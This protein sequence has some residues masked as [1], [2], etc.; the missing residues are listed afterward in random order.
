MA[1]QGCNNLMNVSTQI[2]INTR[3]PYDAILVFIS[4]ILK[5]A[6]TFT[7]SSCCITIIAHFFP[8]RNPHFSFIQKSHKQQGQPQY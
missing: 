2:D 5:N 1:P 3:L 6:D 7:S 4:T 8:P